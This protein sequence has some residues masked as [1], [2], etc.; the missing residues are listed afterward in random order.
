[1]PNSWRFLPD[2]LYF[3]SLKLDAKI[4][5]KKWTYNSALMLRSA[6][7]LYWATKSEQYKLDFE[8]LQIACLKR[9]VKPDGAIDDELQFA[10]LLFENLEPGAFRATA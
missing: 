10:H 7:Q 6:R 4:D 3:D 2:G 5:K 1:M 8:H 9:W